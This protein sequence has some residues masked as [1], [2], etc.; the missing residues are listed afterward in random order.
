MIAAYRGDVYIVQL[1]STRIGDI[2]KQDNNGNSVI[3]YAT[4]QDNED[5]FLF[6][7]TIPNI[8][9]YIKNNL[10]KNCL[11]FCE[12]R[13]RKKIQKLLK[14][15][16]KQDNND[17]SQLKDLPKKKKTFNFST[18]IAPKKTVSLKDFII[19]S[20]IGKG[21]FGQVYLIEKN[22][23]NQLFALKVLKKKKINENNL[24]QYALTEKK[25]LS[26]ISHPFIVKL[27]CTFQNEKFLFMVLDYHPGGDLGE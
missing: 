8:D 22:D 2:N 3:H 14:Q 18:D 15:D 23:K 24:I 16:L 12:E 1:M 20:K 19:H 26:Q 17:A 4:L 13:K 27:H 10:G 21:S 25:I 5:I 9:L 6:L 11:D 7:K